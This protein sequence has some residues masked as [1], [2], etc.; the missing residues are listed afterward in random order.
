MQPTQIKW[1]RERAMKL[2]V[3]HLQS[4]GYDLFFIVCFA[5]LF[6]RPYLWS[7]CLENHMSQNCTLFVCTVSSILC[8]AAL[9]HLQPKRMDLD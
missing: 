1:N 4:S 9:T 8:C 6:V 3:G 5:V 7:P 2:V